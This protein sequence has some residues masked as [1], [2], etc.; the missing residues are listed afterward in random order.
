[1]MV[2]VRVTPH[3]ALKRLTVLTN[4]QCVVIVGFASTTA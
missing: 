2:A 4:Y 1:M 3:F